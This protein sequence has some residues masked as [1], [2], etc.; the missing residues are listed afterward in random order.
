MAKAKKP[1]ER[2]TEL[3]RLIELAD[4]LGLFTPSPSWPFPLSPY[5]FKFLEALR[6]GVE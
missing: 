4:K 6:I 5:D 1:V 2:V 3:A